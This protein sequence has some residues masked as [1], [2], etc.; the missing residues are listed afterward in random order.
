MAA[1]WSE[2]ADS[3]T[4]ERTFDVVIT[5]VMGVVAHRELMRGWLKKSW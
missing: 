2:A 4:K 3:M 1:P 5:N